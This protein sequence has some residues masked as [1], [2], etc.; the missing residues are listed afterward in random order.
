MIQDDSIC[1]GENNDATQKVTSPAYLKRILRENDLHP[2]RNMGQHFLVDENILDKII[3][4]ASPEKG[5]FVL[6]IGAGPGAISLAMA[7]KVA[8]IIAIEWD[9][10]L[11]DLLKGLAKKKGLA[12]LHVIEGD[13]RRLELEEICSAYWGADLV[14]DSR[15]QAPL[16][17]VANLPYYLTT[18]LLFKLLQGKLPLKLLVLMVQFEVAGRMLA[19]PGGKD[20][21]VLSVLCRYY[22]EPHF[23][24]KVSRNVFYPPPAIDS[25]VVSLNVLPTPAVTLSN[26]G[27]FWM[28]VRAAFQKRRKTMLNALEGIAGLGKAEWKEMLEK[29]G[30]SPV[31]RGETCSIEEFASLSDMIYNK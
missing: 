26:E 22:T 7:G 30:I 31:R 18:P 29:A 20:Y 27:L 1:T 15:G 24:F 16:K 5:D 8:G 2:H 4:A 10:G 25:A 19:R 13:V 14:A 3:A 6:D 28:I 21:G 17:V 9:S 12:A 23:L 11:A